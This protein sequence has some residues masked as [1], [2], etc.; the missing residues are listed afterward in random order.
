MTIPMNLDPLLL[1]ERKMAIAC[2]A[3]KYTARFDQEVTK[4]WPD[5]KDR[6]ESIIAGMSWSELAFGPGKGF[7]EQAIEP[8]VKA[9][10]ETH[11]QPILDD[12]VRDLRDCTRQDLADVTPGAPSGTDERGALQ[13]LDVL[14]GLALPAGALVASGAVVAAIVT[15]TKLL[16]FTTIV[17]HWPLLITGLIIGG[18]LSLFGGQHLAKLKQTLQ[19]RFREG[20]L[21]KIRESL[22]GDGVEREGQW[23]PSLKDQL[24]TKVKDTADA[25]RKK[26]DLKE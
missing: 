16:I 12:A 4:A 10:V 22:I 17:V 13:S 15:T 2:W 9:W 23:V 20:L 3:D 18:I 8:T 11:V 6:L 1:H 26:L 21:P 7:G 25:A 24:K 19:S 14:K 5:M